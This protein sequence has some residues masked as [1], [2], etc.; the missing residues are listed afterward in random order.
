MMEAAEH[1]MEQHYPT[2]QIGPNKVKIA[3]SLGRG[4]EDN[5][6]SCE[7]VTTYYFALEF[8]D[9]NDSVPW[10]ISLDGRFVIVVDSPDLVFVVGEV[11]VN[12]DAAPSSPPKSLTQK[13]WVYNDGSGDV[14]D[15]PSQFLLFRNIDTMLQ[16]EAIAMGLSGLGSQPKR[17]LLIRDRKTNVSWGFGFVEFQD[18]SVFTRRD[19]LTS[20]CQIGVSEIRRIQILQN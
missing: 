20:V 6:W 3:Y 9:L 11:D 4:E 2:V 19:C 8:V 16:E 10:S 18:V 17:I 12:V 15:L 1:Y 7:K 13:A 14:G 5:G